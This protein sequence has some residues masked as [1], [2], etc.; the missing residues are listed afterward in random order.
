M[1]LIK[2]I[3]NELNYIVKIRITHFIIFFM[4][5]YYFILIITLV[6]ILQMKL[7]NS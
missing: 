4:N 6:N 5:S 1:I 7:V 3:L 2:N